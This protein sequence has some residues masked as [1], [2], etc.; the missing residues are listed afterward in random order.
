[1][2]R[3]L[4]LRIVFRFIFVRKCIKKNARVTFN[5][6]INNCGSSRYSV[7][8]YILTLPMYVCYNNNN[9]YVRTFAYFHDIINTVK[10]LNEADHI[11]PI[12][13]VLLYYN[14]R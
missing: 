11:V 8:T 12:K 3:K 13:I 10:Y 2:V 1:M 4:F 7:R 9:T 6:L 5:R 14:L